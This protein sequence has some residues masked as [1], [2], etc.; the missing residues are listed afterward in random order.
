VALRTCVAYSTRGLAASDALIPNIKAMMLNGWFHDLANRYLAE[1]KHEEMERGCALI[2]VDFGE[3]SED[4]TRW[5]AASL[6]IGKS[7]KAAILSRHD[8]TFGTL[9]NISRR[10]TLL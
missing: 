6:T 8:R 2:T 4:D 9:A 5:W 3:V 7:S 1:T 10:Y